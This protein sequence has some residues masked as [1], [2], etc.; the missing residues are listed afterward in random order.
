MSLNTD[1]LNGVNMSPLPAS[2]LL[3]DLRHCVSWADSN[4]SEARKRDDAAEDCW[5]RGYK[6]AME[7]V[8]GWLE[9]NPPCLEVEILK[10]KLDE[11]QKLR[12]HMIQSLSGRPKEKV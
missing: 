12:N 2:N 7:E 3:T 4:I 6:Y 9:K 5:N 8:A 1:K 11:C 10:A